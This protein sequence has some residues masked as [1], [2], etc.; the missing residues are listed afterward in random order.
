MA[1]AVRRGDRVVCLHMTYGEAGLSWRKNAHPDILARIR[2]RELRASL[3][4]LGVR[5]QRFLGY[6][7]GRLD[8]VPTQEAVPRIHAVL[9]E[10][11]P[12]AVLTF[13]PDGF[14]GNPDHKTL[15]GWVSAAF[16]L[17]GNPGARLYQSAV[18]ADWTDSFVPPLNE[19]DMFWPGHPVAA[20]HSDLS[21]RLDDHLLEA[22]VEALRAH[23]SQM[24]V[25]FDSYGDN[26]VR[27]LASEEIFL[28]AD[29]CGPCPEFASRG[30]SALR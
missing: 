1:D 3:H 22:K 21:V 15:S 19:F 27:A 7:D 26:F 28:L 14:T 23:S 10:F 29:P 20:T 30:A 18:S 2:R 24:S 11:R 25:L 17:W 5:E 8:E 13:G 12:D 6:P 16:A 4:R 9:D